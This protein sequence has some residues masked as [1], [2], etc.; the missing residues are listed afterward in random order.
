MIFRVVIPKTIDTEEVPSDKLKYLL[1]IEDMIV[2]AECIN[3]MVYING[4]AYP[5][6]FFVEIE[7]DVEYCKAAYP[8]AVMDLYEDLSFGLYLLMKQQNI[9]S[10]DCGD[11][12]FYFEDLKNI[13]EKQKIYPYISRYI[14]E[15]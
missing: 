6:N 7:E 14:E 2:D 11:K 13:F 10:I 3:N 5:S 15:D 9:K 8:A 1:L 12:V 4:E